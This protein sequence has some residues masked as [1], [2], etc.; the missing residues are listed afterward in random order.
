MTLT[1][2]VDIGGTKVAVGVV[3]EAGQVLARVR[4]PIATND[5]ST[6]LADIVELIG[7]VVD[8]HEVSAIG[9]GVAG[10]IDAR[11]CT[12]IFAA[13]LGWVDVAVREV[14]EAGTDLPT[15][16]DDDA[17][18]AAWGEYRFGAGRDESNLVML[19][20]GTGIG[21]GVIDNG[22]LRHGAT[23]SASDVGHLPIVPDGIECSCG[24]RGCLEEYASG[25]ALARAAHDLGASELSRA[26]VVLSLG[27]GTLEGI[28]G[29]HV[30]QAAQRGDSMALEAFDYISN[31]LGRGLAVL[32][33][34]LDPG[35]VVLGGG[36]AEAG[37][38]LLNRTRD[39]YERALPAGKYRSPARLKLAELGS[40]AG[41]IGAANLARIN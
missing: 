3:D 19:T 2:G 26:G 8:G 25:R 11:R 34:V 35:C 16:L 39:A 24:A 9:V 14:I 28:R 18:A 6:T 27:D 36:V 23:G 21:G 40:D 30:T 1:V 37:D 17:N 20:I 32:T 13:N 5:P 12:V 38:I 10:L 41:L 31:W 22:S 7:G 33:A 29:E 4:R 15:V